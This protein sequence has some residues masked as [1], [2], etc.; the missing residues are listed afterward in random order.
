MNVDLVISKLFH[1]E[2]NPEKIWHAFD[3]YYR[4]GY[5]YGQI[6]REFG[7]TPDTHDKLVHSFDKKIA[8]Y[9]T[10][11]EQKVHQVTDKCERETRRL[12]LVVKAKEMD[13]VHAKLEMD[14]ELNRQKQVIADA[15]EFKVQQQ[16]AV[17]YK[18]FDE[19][20]Q[21]LFAE[22]KVLREG[23]AKYTEFCEKF[24]KHLFWYKWLFLS[25]V[26]YI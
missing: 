4:P 24:E 7:I 15:A 9:R 19:E 10:R 20:K 21:E 3:A 17:Q 14:A 25:K 1:I 23:A 12:T 26:K 18:L 13:V 11:A 5:F 8:E 2:D 16:L 22:M 6:E